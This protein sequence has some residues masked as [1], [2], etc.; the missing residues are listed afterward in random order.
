MA[1]GLAMVRGQKLLDFQ[2]R[3]LNQCG[4]SL[5]A[6]SLGPNKDAYVDALAA[7]QKVRVVAIADERSRFGPYGSLVAAIDALQS[8]DYEHVLVLPIDIPCAKPET[9]VKLLEVGGEAV[10]P[11]YGDR[12]GHPVLLSR[13]LAERLRVRDPARSR[14]DELLRTLSQG[15][16]ID[17]EVDDPDI[18][19]DLNTPEA[20]AAYNA[21]ATP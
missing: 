10:V 12:G 11:R 4:V 15:D 21:S 1:K 20:I 14:L 13:R 19:V 7:V 17:L 2:L 6:L 9:I 5:V 8:T 3:R 18:L 16:R